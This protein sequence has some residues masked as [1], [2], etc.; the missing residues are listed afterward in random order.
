MTKDINTKENIRKVTH[1]SFQATCHFRYVF[2]Y[3]QIFCQTY[4]AVYRFLYLF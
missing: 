2:R 4:I 1:A 3:I